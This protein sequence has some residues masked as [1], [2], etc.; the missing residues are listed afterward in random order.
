MAS[1]N[2]STEQHDENHSVNPSS[3]IGGVLQEITHIVNN[4][5]T[6]NRANEQTPGEWVGDQDDLCVNSP[7]SG[8]WSCST[9]GTNPRREDGG[10]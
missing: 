5:I 10:K 6:N 1:Q 8:K 9:G 2:L 4:S 7:C 3:Y